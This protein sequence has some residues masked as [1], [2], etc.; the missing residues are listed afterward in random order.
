MN[1]KYDLLGVLTAKERKPFFPEK[2]ESSVK[3]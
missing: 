2:L 3:G 1:L